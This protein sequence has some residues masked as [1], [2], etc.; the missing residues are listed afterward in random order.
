MDRV[1]NLLNDISSKLTHILEK[2]EKMDAKLQN[3]EKRITRLEV[4]VFEKPKFPWK[5]YIV[6]ILFT[7]F[8]SL[9]SQFVVSLWR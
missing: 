8:M 5:E 9:L 3:H 2:L 6:L 1:E 4:V 7:I